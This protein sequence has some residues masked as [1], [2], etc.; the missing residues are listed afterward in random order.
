MQ[1]TENLIQS[2]IDDLAN[3]SISLTDVLLKLKVIAFKLKNEEL[4]KWVDLELNGYRGKENPPIYRTRPTTLF[5]DLVSLNAKWKGFELPVDELPN[6]LEKVKKDFKILRI[7]QSVPEIIGIIS[8]D[9]T[10]MQIVPNKYFSFFTALVQEGWTPIRIY[11]QITQNIYVD[12]LHNIKSHLLDFLIK[13]SEELETEINIPL[14]Q[15]TEKI[16]NILKSTIGGNFNSSGSMNVY[17]NNGNNSSQA[18]N[19][20]TQRDMNIASGKNATQNIS[21]E[22]EARE[23]LQD[24]IEQVKS[25]LSDLEDNDRE[26]IENQLTILESQSK[27]EILNS[28]IINPSLNVVYN[29]LAGITA[30][31]WFPVVMEQLTILRNY[32]T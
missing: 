29:I 3:F 1:T 6:D 24:F 32:F 28:T 5:A 23:I 25:N 31:A 8:K 11:K 9:L 13:L 20:G 2:T 15:K 4:K 17:V 22:K 16:D 30:N 19:N 10:M 7:Y 12:I 26:D 14:S 21:S 18:I 27:R